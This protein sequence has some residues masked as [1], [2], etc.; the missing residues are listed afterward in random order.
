MGQ[1]KI[2]HQLLSQLNI[3]K[4]LK[5]TE[6]QKQLPLHL[7]Y[8]KTFTFSNKWCGSK[9]GAE[10]LNLRGTRRRW[11]PNLEYRGGGGGGGEED[12]GDHL[13]LTEP[14]QCTVADRIQRDAWHGSVSY[15]HRRIWRTALNFLAAQTPQCERGKRQRAEPQ[16]PFIRR[17]DLHLQNLVSSLKRPLTSLEY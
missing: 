15:Q 5:Q 3:T 11:E 10:Q 1:P 8:F 2:K 14:L 4:P 17:Q 6:R 9:N 13:S 7:P 16:L 12:G